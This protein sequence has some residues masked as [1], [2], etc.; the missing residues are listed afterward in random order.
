MRLIMKVSPDEFNTRLINLPTAI[1][2]TDVDHVVLVV[3]S[4]NEFG[5]LSFDAAYL[6]GDLTINGQPTQAATQ[7]SQSLHFSTYGA[8]P[9]EED[10]KIRLLHAWQFTDEVPERDTRLYSTTTSITQ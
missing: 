3:T 1:D 4:T 8:V 7:V 10:T 6:L 5:G 9:L 2:F